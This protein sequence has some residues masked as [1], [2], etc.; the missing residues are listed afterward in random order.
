MCLYRS[1]PSAI[2]T[3][4]DGSQSQM[5]FEL[6]DFVFV[7]NDSMAVKTFAQFGFLSLGGNVSFTA[8]PVGRNVEGADAM[9]PESV[10][11]VFVYSKDKGQA[12]SV[13][14]EGIVLIERRDANERLYNRKVAGRELLCGNVAVPAHAESL[15]RVLRLR[16]FAAS[17]GTFSG[18]N[19]YN[20]VPV[21]VDRLEGVVWE[22]SPGSAFGEDVRT[23]RTGSMSS[24]N[25][26][27]YRGNATS[28][29]TRASSW[30]D[31]PYDRAS[32]NT[33]SFSRLDAI[34]QRSS[35][36]DDQGDHV[37]SDANGPSLGRPAAP[38][39]VF[40]GNKGN[41]GP[42]Q[43]IAKFTFNADQ[44]R[45]LAFKKDDIITIV[46]RTESKND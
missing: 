1:A 23:N 5:G 16:V 45:D 31:E 22:G 17:D 26:Y 8:G 9:S 2:G 21:S 25:E 13:S 42:R 30:A 37:Y 7:L 3:V 36:F 34:R 11:G 4:G 40:G 41:A 29:A 38:K 43:A 46:K 32:N 39:P 12:R 33:N 20:D 24:P 28:S 15:M 44:S 27:Q 6:T 19:K 10:A 14:P 18:D 35:T